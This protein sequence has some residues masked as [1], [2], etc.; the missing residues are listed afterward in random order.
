VIKTNIKS[1]YETID[2]LKL[3]NKIKE[4]ALLSSFS[5]KII[6]NVFI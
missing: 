5:K 3:I 6:T 4:D 2:T 1:F